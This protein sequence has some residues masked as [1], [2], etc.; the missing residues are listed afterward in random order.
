MLTRRRKANVHTLVR[1]FGDEIRRYLDWAT[2]IRTPFIY[3]SVSVVYEAGAGGALAISDTRPTSAVTLGRTGWI[4]CC[5][6]GKGGTGIP[7]SKL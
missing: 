1:A 6:W 2:I 4:R 3:P 5:I 7:L